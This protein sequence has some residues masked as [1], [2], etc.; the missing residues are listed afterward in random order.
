M[1]QTSCRQ[2]QVVENY[3]KQILSFSQQLEDV[4]QISIFN[5]MKS[6][7]N[8]LWTTKLTGS[9]LDKSFRISS[10]KY[11]VFPYGFVHP[12]VGWFSSRG[13]Y[14]GVPY[15]VAELEN[16]RFF[17][18]FSFI[19]YK[20]ITDLSYKCSHWLIDWCLTPIIAVQSFIELW[21]NQG[22]FFLNLPGPVRAF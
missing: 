20:Y 21:R 17:T 12:P 3:M 10:I 1:H 19:T 5:T 7:T 11:L 22:I 8:V 15:T 4:T 16:I 9:A 6:N 14:S 13:K 2:L 18:S